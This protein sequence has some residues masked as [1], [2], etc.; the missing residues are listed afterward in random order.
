[1]TSLIKHYEH[2]HRYCHKCQEVREVV[3]LEK[4][5]YS[6]HT[7]RWVCSHCHPVFFEKVAG[8]KHRTHPD[9]LPEIER[10]SKDVRRSSIK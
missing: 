4:N 2:T 1:M 9:V 6:D 7:T 8:M 3:Y 5:E 10:P